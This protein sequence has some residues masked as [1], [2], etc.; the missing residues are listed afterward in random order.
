MLSPVLGGVVIGFMFILIA[1]ISKNEKWQMAYGIVGLIFLFWSFG[2]FG[3]GRI[4]HSLVPPLTILFALFSFYTKGT[5]QLLSIVI[6]LIL[7]QQL[8]YVM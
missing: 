8:F 2:F 3:F 4:V 5:A 1:T 6:T 7:L